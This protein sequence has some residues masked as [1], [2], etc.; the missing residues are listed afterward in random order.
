[1]NSPVPPP[2][3]S[4]VATGS[5]EAPSTWHICYA[6]DSTFAFL[7]GI[8]ICSVC[9]TNINASEIWFH[10]LD[11]GITDEQKRKMTELATYYSRSISFYHVEAPLQKLLSLG[12]QSWKN[13]YATWARLFLGSVLPPSVNRVLYLDCDTLVLR[14]LGGLFSTLI[15]V[16]FVCAAVKD[17]CQVLIGPQRQGQDPYFNAGVLLFQLDRWRGTRCEERVLRTIRDTNARLPCVDQGVLNAALAHFILPLPLVYDTFSL[18]P[19]IPWRW[20]LRIYALAPIRFYPEDEYIQACSAP[21]IVHLISGVVGRPWETGNTN[22]FLDE[23]R[24]FKSL[25]PWADE[26]DWP[27]WEH[28]DSFLFRV[29]LFLFRYAPRSFYCAVTALASRLRMR[30]LSRRLEN[31]G[32]EKKPSVQSP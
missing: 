22:P 31:T 18:Y 6:T 10:I 7:A 29:Q 30:R 24:H 3:S 28:Q 21:V 19:C 5:F 20:L 11:N 12:A 15:P 1:M 17:C 16:P 23:F 9:E 8:S 4:H 2:S 27:S 25:S 13:S 26:P 32:L 14:S